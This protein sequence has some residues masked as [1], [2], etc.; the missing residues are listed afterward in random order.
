MKGGGH[1]EDSSLPTLPSIPIRLPHATKGPLRLF[2]QRMAIAL[3]LIV[4]VAMLTYFDRG[5]YA[6]ADGTD[7]D[8]L[9]AFY[10]STV[11]ITTTGYGDVRPE[12]D[13][14]RL[15]TTLL[16][17]P[18]RILFLIVLVGTTVEI[19]AARSREL[20]EQRRWRSRLKSHTIICGYGTK[21]RAAV[22]TLCSQGR[23]PASI[24]VI[25]QT[26][27]GAESAS[28]DGL[29]VVVGD[30]T[31]VD[32]L[33]RAE[34]ETAG[35]IV[36]APERDDTAVLI[37]LTARELNPK[38]MIVVA[39]REEEN[40]HL[41]RQSGADSVITS[42]SAAGRLLGLATHRPRVVELLEDMI[43]L[44]HGLDIIERAVEPHE[45]GPMSNL[46]AT[47]PVLAVVR[48]DELHR[49]DDDRVSELRAGDRIITLASNPKPHEPI[50]ENP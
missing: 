43:T 41:L 23:D 21:G 46:H 12:S 17:T 36:V 11:T 22:R 7:V 39:V 3:G 35:A 47:A 13:T 26:D 49:F 16:I 38:A 18:A 30:A 9:D 1:P 28:D 10:Y 27:V 42:S 29:A 14:A 6:D 48:D 8:L 20:F 44:G 24:V 37:T 4:F 5:G 15:L 25:D 19:L 45:A 31:R 32:V 2:A 33:R 40:V 34:I 50:G